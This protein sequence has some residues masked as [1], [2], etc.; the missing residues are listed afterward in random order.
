ML[1]QRID[2]LQAR[3]KALEE[4]YPLSAITDTKI[5][6]EQVIIHLN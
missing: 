5:E 1:N 6:N 4:T 2:A 3:V